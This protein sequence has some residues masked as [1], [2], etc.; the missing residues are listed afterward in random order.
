MFWLKQMIAKGMKIESQYNG[1]IQIKTSHSPLRSNSSYQ[2]NSVWT[3]V[4]D[5][6]MLRSIPKLMQRWCRPGVKL[7][8]IPCVKLVP[9]KKLIKVNDF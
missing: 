8:E 1:I 6:M 4:D 5:Y 3:E 7:P 9:K 2:G